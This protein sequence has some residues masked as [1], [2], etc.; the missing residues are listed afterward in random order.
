MSLLSFPNYLC[1]DD[2]LALSHADVASAAEQ[3]YMKGLAGTERLASL[4]KLM[5]AHYMKSV[6]PAGDKTFTGNDVRAFEN[7]PYHL[8]SLVAS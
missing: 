2:H 1:S 6:D 7:V 4:H 3:R 8:V 5:A